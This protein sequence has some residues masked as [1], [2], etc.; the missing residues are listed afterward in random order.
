MP[1][2]PAAVQGVRDQT[3]KTQGN[4]LGPVFWVREQTVIVFSFPCV[5]NDMEI[6]KNLL[7]CRQH[8]E[9][10]PSSPEK[11]SSQGQIYTKA[12]G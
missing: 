6:T 10:V 8:W 11:V 9:S 2:Y 7:F 3:I 1:V 12:V 4:I 5:L